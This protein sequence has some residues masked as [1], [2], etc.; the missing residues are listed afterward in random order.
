MLI[1][2]ITNYPQIGIE[3]IIVAF[4]E[5]VVIQRILSMS[6]SLIIIQMSCKD[7]NI[8]NQNSYIYTFST[9]LF[10]QT[11]KTSTCYHTRNY[12]TSV[13]KKNNQNTTNSWESL[14]LC[15]RIIQHNLSHLKYN[16]SKTKQTYTKNPKTRQS[17]TKLMK[18]WYLLGVNPC[19]RA[20]L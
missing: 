19:K 20:A 11:S 9:I 5:T 15:Q 14:I 7:F 13:F 18:F 12:S 4:N 2:N 8:Q 16:C 17:F 10:F 3:T 6:L 1:N